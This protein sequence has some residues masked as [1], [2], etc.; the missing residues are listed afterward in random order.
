MNLD[1]K[2]GLTRLIAANLAVFV[3]LFVPGAAGLVH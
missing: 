1:W 3:L 2:D